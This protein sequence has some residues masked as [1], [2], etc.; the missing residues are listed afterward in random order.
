MMVFTRQRRATLIGFPFP[1]TKRSWRLPEESSIHKLTFVISVTNLSCYVLS[2]WKNPSQHSPMWQ[3]LLSLFSL[4]C[5]TTVV[6]SSL[7]LPADPMIHFLLV[8]KFSWNN[9][10]HFQIQQIPLSLPTHIIWV[11]T[12][13]VTSLFGNKYIVWGFFCKKLHYFIKLYNLRYIYMYFLALDAFPYVSVLFVWQSNI[14]SSH[15]H[16]HTHSHTHASLT[17]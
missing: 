8:W 15:T 16:T 4:V 7:L 12:C 17:V 9:W 3:S 13:L 10:K 11:N 1:E 14:P 2:F 6:K 5:L